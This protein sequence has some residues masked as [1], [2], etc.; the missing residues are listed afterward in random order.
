MEELQ[1]IRKIPYRPHVVILSYYINDIEGV[2]GELGKPR[3]ATVLLARPPAWLRPLVANSHL[4]N[5]A[6][7][8]LFRGLAF[9]KRSQYLDSNPLKAYLGGLFATPKIWAAHREQL[10]EI[11]ALVRK[12]RR[13]LI[14]VAFPDLWDVE[15]TRPW[16][17]RVLD[18]FRARRVP[19]V[20]V[21]S[22]VE[23]EPPQRLVVNLVDSH[24]NVEVHRRVADALLPIVRE[25]EAE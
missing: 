14:V 23:G 9:G 24:P 16:T 13:E 18:L 20:D 12:Q 3:P 2:A 5:F 11:D 7:W 21:A 4:S 17:Q 6:Y 1:A 10:R 19:V 8:R 15:G 25:L 22:L